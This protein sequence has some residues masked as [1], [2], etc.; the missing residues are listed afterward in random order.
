M[1][2]LSGHFSSWLA[3]KEAL[4]EVLCAKLKELEE[5]NRIQAAKLEAQAAKLEAQVAKLEAQVAI[6]AGL[7]GKVAKDSHNSSKPPSTEG[8][9]KRKSLREPS[10]R[11]PGG[12]KGPPGSTLQR[13]SHPHQIL[14]PETPRYCDVCGGDLSEAGVE[15]VETR[16]VID[17]A[18]LQWEVTEYRLRKVR[19][20]CGKLHGAFVPEGVL[21]PA[22]CSLT[23]RPA[24]PVDLLRG[25]FKE[26]FSPFVTSWTAPCTF[27]PE[28]ELAGSDLHRRMNRALSRHT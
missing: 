7:N 17:L 20:S 28:R 12:Q 26:C 11:K 21:Q 19:C 16:Q 25:R 9:R 22:Q 8:L 24:A 14:S 23:L 18:P 15:A 5:V 6:I 27:R 1:E 2:D 13:V 4:I 3:E 10:G